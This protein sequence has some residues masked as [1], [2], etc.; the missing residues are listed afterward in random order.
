MRKLPFA[1]VVPTVYGQMIVNRH[2][3]NQANALLKTGRAVDHAE[4]DL[5][6]Q[7]LR[8]W[9]TELTVLDIGA[10]FGTYS[11]AL[12][13]AV[14]ARG[15][16]HAFEAQRIIFNMLA[17]S[18]ALNGITNIH[19]HNMAVGDRE[20]SIPLPQFDYDRPLNFGSVELGPVQRE[21]LSQER[22]YDAEQAE[23]VPLTTI[24]RFAFSRVGLIKID[25]EGMEMAVLDGAAET[26]ARCRPVL[27][28]EFLKS[29]AEAMRKRLEAMAYTVHVIAMNYLCIPQEAA[30]RI[31]LR[32][33]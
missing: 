13:H 27:Y 4:I 18:V 31:D 2:D 22:R 14:G 26:I 7:I 3:I 6:A 28:V 17:G 12:V 9:G 23:D 5:L 8:R 24:D 30:G 33:G 19:C 10:N 25:V 21:P 16:V 20:G 1:I 11:M 32:I 15:K 29:D